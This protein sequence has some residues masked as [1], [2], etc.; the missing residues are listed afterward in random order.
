MGPI[1]ASSPKSKLFAL[2]K[3]GESIGLAFQIIDD[4]LDVVGTTEELGKSAGSDNRKKKL[5]YPLLFGIDG[6]REKAKHLISAAK[7]AIKHFSS[8]ADPL[9]EIAEYLGERRA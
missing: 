6:A 1:L 9:R 4:I 8:K 7:D 3:Y 2:T 5:T